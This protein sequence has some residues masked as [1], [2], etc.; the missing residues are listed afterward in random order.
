MIRHVV[1]FRFVDSVADSQISEM[2]I[3]LDA[4]PGQIP[5][6]AAFRHGRDLGI[7]PGNFAYSVTA[8]FASEDDFVTYRN[9]PDHQSL[10][11]A[12][13]NDKVEQRAAVQ[14]ELD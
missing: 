11:A 14:F 5:E 3:A 9:H 12:H 4:L 6:I 8:D 10:I 1:L 2:G 13:I 7:A